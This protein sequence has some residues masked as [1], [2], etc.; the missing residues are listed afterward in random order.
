MT[1]NDKKQV[2]K[3]HIQGVLSFHIQQ[4]MLNL[5][6]LCPLTYSS[7]LSKYHLMGTPLYDN[8]A[9]MSLRNY[10]NSDKIRKLPGNVMISTKHID[11][12]KAQ[13]VLTK[14]SVKLDLTGHCWLIFTHIL[15]KMEATG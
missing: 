7:N 5:S 8:D 15:G 13:S 3:M 1:D 9:M 10:A 2:D 14:N 11:G 12:S 4:F 6:L